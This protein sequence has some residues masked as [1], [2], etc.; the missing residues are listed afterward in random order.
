[1]SITNGFFLFSVNVFSAAVG[2]ATVTFSPTAVRYTVGVN[3]VY[4]VLREFQWRTESEKKDHIQPEIDGRF[5]CS[6]GGRQRCLRGARRGVRLRLSRTRG[7]R[8]PRSTRRNPLFGA[9]PAADRVYPDGRRVPGRRTTAAVPWAGNRLNGDCRR[10]TGHAIGPRL[11]SDWSR[12][13]TAGTRTR[14]RR[15]GALRFLPTTA[16]AVRVNKSTAAAALRNP[17]PSGRVSVCER[18]C[19]SVAVRAFRY[20]RGEEDRARSEC[21]IQN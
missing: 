13:V 7:A 9:L 20:G 21:E 17:V 18:M 2:G 12:P 14:G 4:G 15:R 16:P 8:T 3:C 5:R 6:G 11:A 19:V 1:M 10:A